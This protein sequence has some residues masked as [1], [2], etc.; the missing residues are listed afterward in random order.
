MNEIM[1]DFDAGLVAGYAQSITLIRHLQN[2]LS[3]HTDTGSQRK[4]LEQAMELIS[5]KIE[6]NSNE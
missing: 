2:T 4:I 5:E 1:D 6:T 3:P